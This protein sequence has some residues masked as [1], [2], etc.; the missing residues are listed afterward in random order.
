MRTFKFHKNHHLVR[1]LQSLR[2]NSFSINMEIRWLS[3]RTMLD[4]VF[5]IVEVVDLEIFSELKTLPAPIFCIEKD[6]SEYIEVEDYVSINL[7]FLK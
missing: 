2:Y 4:A 7:S 3:I 5:I 6:Y 1:D